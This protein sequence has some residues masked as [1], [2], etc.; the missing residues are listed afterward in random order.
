MEEY[1]DPN[2][3]GPETLPEQED[4]FGFDKELGD[5][6]NVVS[7]LPMLISMD[8]RYETE[9]LTSAVLKDA[10]KEAERLGGLKAVEERYNDPE[11]VGSNYNKV[12]AAFK[13]HPHKTKAL[14]DLVAA[15]R[16]N[17]SDVEMYKRSMNGIYRLLYPAPHN[18]GNKTEPFEEPEFDPT[19]LDFFPEKK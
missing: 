2:I 13:R 15:I 10:V 6:V 11:K 16:E 5:Y 14:N 7:T 9:G 1:R 3:E 8:E 17:P 19:N 12:K 18:I 4:I